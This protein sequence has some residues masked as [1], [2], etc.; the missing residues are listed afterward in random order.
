VGI[1]GELFENQ[2]LPY[3]V[4]A[5]L[6]KAKELSKAA[7]RDPA[8]AL[9]QGTHQI[10]IKAQHGMV[11]DTME[12]EGVLVARPRH[13]GQRRAWRDTGGDSGGRGD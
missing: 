13:I 5:C 12:C 8:L 1:S 2:F 9:E 4:Q 7:I 3:M 10:F 6:V 11:D